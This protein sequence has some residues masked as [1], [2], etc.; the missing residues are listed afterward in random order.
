[1]NH[2]RGPRTLL[3]LTVL[4]GAS[5]RRPESVPELV[6]GQYSHVGGWM[7]NLA[8]FIWDPPT[9]QFELNVGFGLSCEALVSYWRLLM[10][11]S[12]KDG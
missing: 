7:G 8:G 10:Q 6:Q 11:D 5:V 9:R 1:M 4:N 3:S 2:E 12:Y